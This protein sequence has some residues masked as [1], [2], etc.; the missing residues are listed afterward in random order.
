MKRSFVMPFVMALVLSFALCAHAAPIGE[1]RAT[2][3]A[4]EHA[5]LTRPQ[6]RV[7]AFE[8]DH[9]G[10]RQVYEVDFVTDDMKY[11]YKIDAESGEVVAYEKKGAASAMRPSYQGGGES[12]IGGDRAKEIAMAHA[13]VDA[14]RVYSLKVKRDYEHGRVVY[15]VEF[16]CDGWEYD[17][18]IDAVSGEVIWWEKDRD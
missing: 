8:L 9:V 13:G 12:Y 3:I 2:D 10:A 18:D 11:E 15:E 5:G 7:V 6:V 14:S 1:E 4:I 17:F 16:K